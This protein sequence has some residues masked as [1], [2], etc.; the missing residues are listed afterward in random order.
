MRSHV[1]SEF[2]SDIEG[3]RELRIEAEAIEATY[4]ANPYS[5]YLRKNGKRPSKEEAAGI[6]RVFGGRVRADD[7]TMQ[8]SRRVR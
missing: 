8:P 5:T 4:G 6:G 2:V 7:G 3:I 1:Q